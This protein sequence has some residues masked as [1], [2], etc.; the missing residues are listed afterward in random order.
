MEDDEFFRPE[1]PKMA[2]KKRNRKEKPAKSGGLM[3]EFARP[4]DISDSTDDNL[5][6]SMK[7]I[8]QLEQPEEEKK[9]KRRTKKE[10]MNTPETSKSDYVYFIRQ[11]DGKRSQD[12]YVKVGTTDNVKKYRES[13]EMGTPYKLKTEKVI[14]APDPEHAGKILKHFES[15]HPQSGNSW[16]KI[17]RNDLPEFLEN[18]KDYPYE[19]INESSAKVRK[20]AGKTERTPADKSIRF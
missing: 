19:L 13:I 12:I 10:S 16:Y 8:L 7:N 2:T 15:L 9:P 4:D 5:S 11:M 14:R 3:D 20:T 6:E 17:S 1:K 18:Y